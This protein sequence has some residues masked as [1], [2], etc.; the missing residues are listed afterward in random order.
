MVVGNTR[1]VFS[2]FR[3]ITVKVTLIVHGMM[4]VYYDES[5]RSVSDPLPVAPTKVM[6]DRLSHC[7][8]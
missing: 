8:R 2:E 7:V 5:L 4:R 3:L 1:S 6:A